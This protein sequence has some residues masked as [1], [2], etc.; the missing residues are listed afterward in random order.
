LLR[1]EPCWMRRRVESDCAGKKIAHPPVKKGAP[2]FTNAT[3]YSLTKRHL[4]MTWIVPPPAMMQSTSDDAINGGTQ[5]ATPNTNSTYS[6]EPNHFRTAGKTSH[7]HHGEDGAGLGKE[8]SPQWLAVKPPRFLLRTWRS[9]LV[10]AKEFLTTGSILVPGHARSII[11]P[12][13]RLGGS[14]NGF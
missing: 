5:I 9:N 1:A 14:T 7:P 4:A 2:T 10:V 11:R 6:A 8:K 12:Y 13:V 3:Q